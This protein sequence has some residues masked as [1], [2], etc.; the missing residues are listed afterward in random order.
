[1]RMTT[2]TAAGARRNEKNCIVKPTRGCH[3]FSTSAVE[4][5][6]YHSLEMPVPPPQFQLK[7]AVPALEQ[8]GIVKLRALFAFNRR[9]PMM[10][11]Q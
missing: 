8:N 2:T 4:S 9:E 11:Y 7:I 5:W 1:M 10:R 6:R 3:L